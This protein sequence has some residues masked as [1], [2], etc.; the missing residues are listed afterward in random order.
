MERV[1]GPGAMAGRDGKGLPVVPRLLFQGPVPVLSRHGFHGAR[2]RPGSVAGI[3]PD[4]ESNV[5]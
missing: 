1:T 4:Y 5:E 2:E 3:V